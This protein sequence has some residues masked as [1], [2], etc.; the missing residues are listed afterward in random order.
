MPSNGVQVLCS[1]VSVEGL[2]VFKMEP[3]PRFG[4][5]FRGVQPR[6]FRQFQSA[7][8]KDVLVGGA[9]QDAN[10]CPQV[11][12]DLGLGQDVRDFGLALHAQGLDAVARSPRSPLQRE[13]RSRNPARVERGLSWVL[14]ACAH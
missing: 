4:G 6:V 14:R 8:P 3:S 12:W 1:C 5:G 13:P 11:M 10:L 7:D 9:F 2:D